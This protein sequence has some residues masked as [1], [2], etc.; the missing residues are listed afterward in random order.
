[1][2]LLYVDES[3][4]HGQFQ[5]NRAYVL[6]GLAIHE[7]DAAALQAELSALVRRHVRGD[8]DAGAHE[9]HAAEIRNPRRSHSIWRDTDGNVRR[10]L[11][12]EALTAIAQHTVKRPDR[13]LRA[14]AMTFDPSTPDVQRVSFQ[15]LLHRFD[16]FLDECAQAGD[17]HNGIAIAD[18]THLE[19][20]I[21]QWAEGWRETATA[22]GQ[23]DHLA[24][25][26]LFANSKAT[27]LLQAADLVAWSVWRAHGTD[28]G[29][30]AWLLRLGGMV[31]VTD[32]SNRALRR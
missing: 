19:R 18:E 10:K 5:G 28:P 20:Q 30:P 6:A 31:E 12:E 16:A 22:L 21:Q 13:P 15:A 9:L 7:D 24:D 2:Y 4:S 11:L 3:G 1:M 32:P 25:V 8:V 26:P 17:P 29:D 14:F 27:R 23:L